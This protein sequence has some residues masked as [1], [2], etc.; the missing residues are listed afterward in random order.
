[1]VEGDWCAEVGVIDVVF[2]D[3]GLMVLDVVSR[4]GGRSVGRSLKAQRCGFDE[5]GV[6]V[7]V[8]ARVTTWPMEANLCFP[9]RLCRGAVAGFA[10]LSLLC[11]RPGGGVIE[12]GLI[13]AVVAV[14]ALSVAEARAHNR[15]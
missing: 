2:A 10:A 12:D 9:V 1:M 3:F 4:F 7:V 13:D 15:E 8:V 11:G 14:S 5:S 6:V